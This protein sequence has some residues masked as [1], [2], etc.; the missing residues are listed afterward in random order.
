MSNSSPVII[1]G[2]KLYFPMHFIQWCKF[3][4]YAYYH[5]AGLPLGWAKKMPIGL[6]FHYRT[7]LAEQ[8]LMG[9]VLKYSPMGFSSRLDFLFYFV[10][11]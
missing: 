3:V 8:Y 5:W 9:F 6:G 11:F 10:L 4:F 7:Y 2:P 1:H